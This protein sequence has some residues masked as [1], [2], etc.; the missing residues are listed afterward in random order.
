MRWPLLAALAAA[1]AAAARA[2]GRPGKAGGGR[3]RQAAGGGSAAAAFQKGFWCLLQSDWSIFA[4][5]RA[6]RKLHTLH[7]TLYTPHFTLYV[8][9]FSIGELYTVTLHSMAE[10]SFTDGFTGGH[11][12]RPQHSTLHMSTL[13][14]SQTEYQIKYLTNALYKSDTLHSLTLQ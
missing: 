5:S 12:C 11:S 7:L 13:T 2:A 3:R 14:D 1:V 9:N 6:L 10:Q 8:P 4:A